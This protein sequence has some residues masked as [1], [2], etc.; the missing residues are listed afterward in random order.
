[1]TI[2]W[3]AER[4]LEKRKSAQSPDFLDGLR[5]L[6]AQAPPEWPDKFDEAVKWILEQG[7]NV[8]ELQ[9]RMGHVRDEMNLSEVP[10]SMYVLV[11]W[12]CAKALEKSPTMQTWKRV[13]TLRNNSVQLEHWL[14]DAMLIYAEEKPDSKECYV[15]LAKEVFGAV[16]R[17][18]LESEFER[19]NEARGHLKEAWA[20]NQEKLTKLW[21]G[22]D[23]NDSSVY[24]EEFPLFHVLGDLA[25]LEFVNVV[26]S[27]NNPYLIETA[28]WA[29][30]VGSNYRLWET[31]SEEVPLAFGNEGEWNGMIVIPLL[32]NV[33]H[34]QLSR[35]SE[36]LSLE[37]T[38]IDEQ[39]VRE[40][41]T[42]LAK[43]VVS[44]LAERED[45]TSLFS[46]WS[47]WLMR[48][49]LMQGFKEKEK[50]RSSAVVDAALIDAIGEQLKKEKAVIVADPP[51]DAPA[52]EAW[53]R[54][55][56]LALMADDGFV[57]NPDFSAYLDEW[58]IS[59]DDW[60]GDKGKHLRARAGLVLIMNKDI[61]G[62][63][64]RCLAYLVEKSG[65]PVGQWISWWETIQ[66]L[67]EI[68]EFGDADAHHSEEYES[69]STAARLLFFAFSVGLSVLDQYVQKEETRE[70]SI[71]KDAARLHAALEMAVREMR[72]I[73]SFLSRD[74][75]KLAF[76]HLA[77]RRLIWEGTEAEEEKDSVTVFRSTDKPT[78]SDYL[79]TVKNDERE[80]VSILQS[81]LLNL[82]N[83]ELIKEKLASSSIDLS[84]V[85]SVVKRLN[86][87]DPRKYPIDEAQL[88]K[89]KKL[90]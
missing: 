71:G 50:I 44:V 82:N 73:D 34:R 42:N 31:L 8:D 62:D 66:S 22:L 88:C 32:L 47:T 75:W 67:R 27:S 90:I 89:L 39:C 4:D 61:P 86:V 30:S 40:E 83:P 28:L 3:P 56:V 76:L 69:R 12:G 70:S 72:E 2:Q 33:A 84:A 9:E 54:L 20:N 37:S 19:H 45:A 24:M 77:V 87:I 53:C 79:N 52:W 16:D 11:V 15:N 55:A 25:P 36:T 85:I 58:E 17:F 35:A 21:Q 14:A 63:A 7:G 74:Q 10:D 18:E 38:D 57:N 23:W 81:V 13:R 80:T 5:Q 78:F 46:R 59:I 41:I 51:A 26:S 68:V 6:L 49:L 1:M 43:S 65:D 29:A 60:A 64:A 48:Q